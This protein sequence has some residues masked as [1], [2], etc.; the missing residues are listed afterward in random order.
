MMNDIG[1]IALFAWVKLHA[2]LPMRVLYVLSD[3][4]YVLLYKIVHYR[5]KVVRSNMKASFPD[6]TEEELRR[7]ERDFY[8]HLADFIVE[9]IKLAHISHEDLNKRAHL[10]NP[11]L[12][13]K[14]MDDGH[15]CV[16]MMMGHYG[17]WEYFCGTGSLF[18]D[19]RL[20][21]VYRPLKSKPFD[22]LFIRLRDQFGARGIKKNDTIR[23]TITL[24]KNKTRSCLVLLSDQTPSPANI[25]YWTQFLNQDTP[26]IVG[27]ERIATK[28]NLPVVFSN[29][30]KVSRGHYSVEFR[31]VADKPGELSEFELTERYVRMMEESIMQN[32]AYWLWTHKRWKHKR[33]TV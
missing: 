31:L 18:K 17:N 25:H 28:M 13:D 32:P 11:E 4:L 15:P 22:R 8:H 14:L 6:K 7:L 10:V 21:Q 2:L 1:Y 29:M 9:I 19:A 16:I 24:I 30:K 33:G 26:V 20:C 23:D 3:V 12:I 5:L 27:G